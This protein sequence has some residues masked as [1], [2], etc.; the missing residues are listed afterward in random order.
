[1]I[2]IGLI[3]GAFGIGF[4]CW[5]RFTLAVYALPSFAGVTAGLA[6]FHSG[7]GVTGAIIVGVIAGVLTLGA[8]Q[9]AFAVS[10][11]PF[12]R[13]AI[14]LLF[15]APAAVA[16][17]HGTLGLAQI[18][19]PSAGWRGAFAII[20]A[21]IGGGTALGADDAVGRPPPGRPVFPA[22]F[23][24]AA[25]HGPDRTRLSHTASSS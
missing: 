25:S 4:L 23:G 13:A 10:R 20:G 19:V 12:I 21:I 18:G 8:R 14:A 9:L 24:A 1:M 22:G 15:A 17:Y 2:I 5:L 16:G 3:L 11:S 7:A 6:A